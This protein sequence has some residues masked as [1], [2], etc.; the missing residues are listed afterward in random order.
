MVGWLV[1]CLTSACVL[2]AAT[3]R[4][5]RRGCAEQGRRVPAALL[6]A[7]EEDGTAGG[8]GAGQEL[9]MPARMKGVRRPAV[10]GG[11]AKKF[12]R[13]VDAAPED[14]ECPPQDCVQHSERA[15]SSAGEVEI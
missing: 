11:G 7:A 13:V 15:L 3:L 4:I 9:E 1:L 5:S 2:A 10:Y 8:A 6:P 12:K 14:D